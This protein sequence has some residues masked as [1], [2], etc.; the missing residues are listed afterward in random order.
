MPGNSVLAA[1]KPVML[2]IMTKSDR[3]TPVKL[4]L[5]ALLS[6]AA[7][8]ECMRFVLVL[9][10]RRG[11]LARDLRF[12]SRAAPRRIPTHARHQP[13]PSERLRAPQLSDRP[14]DQPRRLLD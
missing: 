6:R 8:R 13:S 12:A 11:A 10:G 2:R 7:P 14:P 5:S 4:H 1:A 3:E 9:Q